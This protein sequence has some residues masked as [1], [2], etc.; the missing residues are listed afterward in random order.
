MVENNKT[1]MRIIANRRQL[2]ASGVG[3][4][5]TADFTSAKSAAET[6]SL[7]DVSLAA[8][9]TYASM[10]LAKDSWTLGVVQSRV[11]PVDEKNI[12]RTR[13][14]NLNHMVELIDAAQNY[15]GQKEV[16][17][18]HEFPITGYNNKWTRAD[19]LKI[20][21]EFPG[22]ESELLCR[23]AKEHGCYIVFGTYARDKNWPGHAL[24]LTTIIGPDGSILDH[25][26][27][28]RNIKGVFVGFDL[29][30]T[31]VYD[32][33]DR[34]VEMYGRDAMIPVTRTPLGNF[35]TASIQR[36]PEYFR[37]QAMKGA[38][39]I[40]RTASGGFVEADIQ[41]TSLYNNVYTAIS[42]NSI[43]QQHTFFE[44]SGAG[45]SA[46]YG[47]DGKQIAR[48]TSANECLVTA[49]IPIADFRKRHRQPVVHDALYQDV[50]K[51][52]RA[53]YAPNLF[54]D[55]LPTDGQD[56]RHYLAD[57]SRWK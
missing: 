27:K 43:S 47:P 10:P 28:A 11:I 35:A 52:Y 24:S 34:F 32:V 15:G 3:L 40:L 50:N 13:K 25:H 21:I 2:L 6:Q 12:A 22:E 19:V 16:L 8:D 4:A 17:L 26:W 30:T 53:P 44:D 42:N 57:K 41:A 54:S 33:L 29:F 46:I 56:A 49:R 5:L 38:E 20:A 14:E 1:P 39:V 23:K 55:Y 36:E 31:T 51:S 18:F 7:P 37:A 45:G 48:A 9:G